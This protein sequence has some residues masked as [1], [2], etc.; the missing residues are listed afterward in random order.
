MLVAAGSITTRCDAA[1]AKR[2]HPFAGPTPRKW[3]GRR[4]INEKVNYHECGACATTTAVRVFTTLFPN[5]RV[6]TPASA[7]S[8][9]AAAAAAAATVV[10]VVVSTTHHMSCRCGGRFRPRSRPRQTELSAPAPSTSR[11]WAAAVPC[12]SV[13]R[14]LAAVAMCSCPEGVAAPTS[15][16]AAPAPPPGQPRSRTRT[17]TPPCSAARPSARRSS[18]PPLLCIE[19]HAPCALGLAFQSPTALPWPIQYWS[20]FT[21]VPITR[22]GTQRAVHSSGY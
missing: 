6:V 2:S 21:K 7:A 1:Q 4:R 19:C 22:Y 20:V 5:L 15:V 17:T 8:A 18:H 16:G 9:A 13:G 10:V 12:R 14:P 11:P 3:A